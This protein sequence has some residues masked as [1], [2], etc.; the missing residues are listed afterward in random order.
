MVPTKVVRASAAPWKLVSVTQSDARL[1]LS[2]FLVWA[3]MPLK[4]K[5]GEP[6]ASTAKPT[7]EPRGK[8][9]S[10]SVLSV[11]KALGCDMIVRIS[12][13]HERRGHAC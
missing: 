7:I 3:D 13:G 6:S 9:S 2:M 4:Q 10:R 12:S 11:A 1:S 5:M 8:P